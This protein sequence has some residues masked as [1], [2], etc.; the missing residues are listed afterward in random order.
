[1]SNRLVKARTGTSSLLPGTELEEQCAAENSETYYRQHQQIPASVVSP[2]PHSSAVLPMPR[3]S[4]LSPPKHLP[5][6]PAS[7]TAAL[8]DQQKMP[9][10][11]P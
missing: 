7:S 11:L 9:G 5:R 2:V 6:P 4:V 10:Y 8:R 3:P 1:M